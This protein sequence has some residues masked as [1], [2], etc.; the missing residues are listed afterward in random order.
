M[1][2]DSRKRI[3]QRD[4]EL[5]FLPIVVVEPCDLFGNRNL[6]KRLHVFVCAV[7]RNKR[8]KILVIKRKSN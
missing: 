5:Q 4:G 3:N 7:L 6:D 8:N 1:V 2:A